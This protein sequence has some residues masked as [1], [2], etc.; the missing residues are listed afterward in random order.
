[1]RSSTRFRSFVRFNVLVALLAGISACTTANR[2]DL[3][4]MTFSSDPLLGKVIWHDL[5]T[6]D[7]SSSREFYSGLFGWTFQQSTGTRGED[8]VL[9]RQGDL[10]VAGLLE[11]DVP[12]DENDYSRWLPYVSVADVDTAVARTRTAGGTVVASARN[13]GLGRVAA[14]LDPQGAVIGLARS[15]IGDPD[16]MTTAPGVGK[17]VWTELLADDPQ[18]A[19][20]FYSA[21]VPYQVKEIER[22][23]GKYLFLASDGIDRAGIFQKPASDEYAATWLTAFG[24]EDPAAAAAKAESLGG[25]IIVPASAELRDGTIAIITDPAGAIL[26]LQAWGT[27]GAES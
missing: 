21:L 6:E 20:A 10:L 19:A 8:Y 4:N 22:R 23:G 17:P 13:V 25:R 14:V 18:A 5:V 15:S 27:T 24:V 16:D 1:M 2:P 26:V 9:A 12:D 3:G 11:V 7:L